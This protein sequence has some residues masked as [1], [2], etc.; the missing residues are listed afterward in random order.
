VTIDSIEFEISSSNALGLGTEVTVMKVPLLN[1]SRG[2]VILK[3]VR[4]LG[5]PGTAGVADTL[6]VSIAPRR[7]DDDSPYAPLGVYR[8]YPPVGQAPTG[9]C[10]AQPV[11]PVANYVLQ[12]FRDGD[13]SVIVLRLRTKAAGTVRLR[14]VRV[15]YVQGGRLLFQDLNYAIT[16][17]VRAGVERRPG[18]H[19]TPCLR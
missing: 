13:A 3:N 6:D 4:V 15:S 5:A 7:S 18:F 12:P 2:A 8:Y 9:T 19:E 10:V 16:M 11:A 1:R 14:G 17:A